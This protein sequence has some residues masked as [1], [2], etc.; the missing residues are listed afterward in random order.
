MLERQDNQEAQETQ[1]RLDNRALVVQA[2]QVLKVHLDRQDNPDNP[3]SLEVKPDQV[4]TDH[5]DPPDRQDNQDNQEAPD[6]RVKPEMPVFQ[7]K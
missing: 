4:K 3:D 2:N 6:N 7:G 5:Q 1:G